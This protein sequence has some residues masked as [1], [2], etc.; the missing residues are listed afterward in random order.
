MQKLALFISTLILISSLSLAQRDA[1]WSF[2]LALPKTA[3]HAT[4]GVPN[5]MAVANQ[6]LFV[7]YQE[8]TSSPPARTIK[9]VHRSLSHPNA[10]WE[11]PFVFAPEYPQS[12]PINLPSVCA[13]PD[14]LLH[15]SYTV[16]LNVLRYAALNPSTFTWQEQ[17]SL[18]ATVTYRIGFHQITVDQSG[19]IHL[20]WH[21]GDPE[22][23]NQP[24]EIWY[25]RKTSTDNQFVIRSISPPDGRHSAFPA[26]DLSGA[27]GDFLAV[28]WRDDSN[29]SGPG[30]ASNW[31]IL[32]S[33]SEDG[34]ANWSA[35]FSISSESAYR[36]W[37]PQL[38]VDRHNIAHLAFHRYEV[39]TGNTGAQ[40][41]LGHSDDHM[42]SWHQDQN[43]PGFSIVAPLSERQ[44]LCKSAYDYLHDIVWFFWKQEYLPGQPGQPKGEDILGTW[45][46][47]L[48]Q[49]ISSPWE[50]L[51]G[52]GSGFQAAGFHNFA[53]GPNGTVYATYQVG[54]PNPRNNATIYVTERKI[55]SALLPVY[56][57]LAADARNVSLIVST[58]FA[59]Q[60]TVETSE[61]L[62]DWSVVPTA[63]WTGTGKDHSLVLNRPKNPFFI[64]LAAHR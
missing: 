50:N 25:A 55:P 5:T 33:F 17:Q 36:E 56:H 58:E 18:A 46:L 38:V 9:F 4:G 62:R 8:E 39:G 24:C 35:P 16:G 40:V 41:C 37:D 29:G 1:D 53:I 13:G 26:T 7:F 27:P 15:V 28:A 6:R 31:D 21:D 2:P 23:L 34:G 63:S 42:Q 20:F 10:L 14:G 45:V 49:T 19:T 52:I 51:T 64:R 43:Q 12:P 30:F 57:G 11:G 44:S 48:G 22:D 60:Y 59:V 32:G 47:R 54:D 3:P 61:N